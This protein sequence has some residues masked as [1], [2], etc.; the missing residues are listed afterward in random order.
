MSAPKLRFKD[1]SAKWNEVILNDF[2]YFI[3][4][5]RGKNYP[6]END[7]FPEGYCLFLNAYN[8]SDTGLTFKN[9]NWL[10][11]EKHKSLRKGTAEYRDLILTT[12]GS[13]LGKLAVYD[14]SIPYNV[15]RINSAMLLIRQKQDIDL[16]YTLYLFK[17][18]ILPKFI[19]Q[20]IVGSAQPHLTVK[21]LKA[22]STYIPED[23][24]EQQKIG[25]FFSLLN[26]KIQKQQ[27]KVE[28]LKEQKKGLM[29]KIF[30]QELRFKAEGGRE[31]PKWE[32]KQLNQLLFENK[33]RN[34]NGEFTKEGVLSVSGTHGVINQIEFQGRSFAGESVAN[35]HVVNTGDIVYTKSP[36]KYN[37]Y[38][39]I[40]VNKGKPGI[41]STLY[42][43]YSCNQE[44]SGEYLDFYFQLNDTTNRY[45]KPLVNKGAKNDMK[46]NN[47]QVLVGIVNIPIFNEQKKIVEFLL[48]FDTKIV[49][50][51]LRLNDLN[52]QKKGFMQK[53]F[54]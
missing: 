51:K 17:D 41:V 34:I 44:V 37:P 7:F 40:K 52:E 43:V 36:L 47:Q 53:M 14:E 54:V 25:Y 39:I 33:L 6:N 48:K 1:H 32:K 18:A 28:L 19:N 50:E 11:K 10:T 2:F 22:Y 3:D 13:K 49:A 5:D 16:E 30:S 38:G 15:V 21:D 42:A 45:L 46:V 4:G 20:H 9:T 24:I 23:V 27:E 29:Q 35:Y 26:L 8:I 31:F 12:R